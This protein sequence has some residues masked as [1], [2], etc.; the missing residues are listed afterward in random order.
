MSALLGEKQSI[1]FLQ[2]H[3]QDTS[4]YYLT[5]EEPGKCNSFSRESRIMEINLYILEL[6]E[7]GIQNSCIIILSEI[8]KNAL[9]VSEK[10]GHIDKKKLEN[11]KV[12]ENSKTESCN[13]A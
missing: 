13:I 3:I 8:K 10:I 5:C 9:M 7:N 11:I 1:K 4:K 6:S 2:C 12:Y